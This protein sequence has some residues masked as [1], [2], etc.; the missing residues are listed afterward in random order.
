[1][2]EAG[3]GANKDRK[4]KKKKT[5]GN[6]QAYKPKTHNVSDQ[7]TDKST[8]LLTDRLWDEQTDIKAEGVPD[9]QPSEKQIKTRAS[10]YLNRSRV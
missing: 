4:R 3:L 5:D 2:T 7:Q 10:Q 1:M 9:L 8:E 6:R